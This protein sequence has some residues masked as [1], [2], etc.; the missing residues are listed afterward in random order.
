MNLERSDMRILIVTPAP[1]RSLTGNRVTALRWSRML[2]GLGHRVSIHQHFDG[3]SCDLMLALHAKRSARDIERFRRSRPASPLLLA[4][5]GT[6]LYRDIHR[7]RAARRSL[8][9]ADRLILLQ[10]HGRRELPKQLQA[11]TR[12]IYQS[13]SAPKSIPQPLHGVFEVAVIGHLRPVKDPFRAARAARLLPKSSKIRIVHLGAALTAS[14]ERRARTEMRVNSR[15]QWF[16]ERPRWQTMR[17]LARCRLLVLSSKMEG[18]A[19]VV[20][21]AIAASVP[22]V[23]SRVSGSIGLLGDDYPGYFDVGDTRGLAR[24][25]ARAETNRDFYGKLQSWCCRLK[26]LFDPARERAAWYELLAEIAARDKSSM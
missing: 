3:Q 8:E 2:R 26:P 22:V 14:M 5:T 15:Y 1:P 19:N 11:K 20:S 10:P 17:Q 18:G 9:L 16:G 24:L 7:S 6:D 25:L 4:L 12:V 13:V 23:C 21:E